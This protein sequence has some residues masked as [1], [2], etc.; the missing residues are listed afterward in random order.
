MRI[1]QYVAVLDTCVLAP[2]PLAD[3]LLRLGAEEFFT[4][5]WSSDILNELGGVLEKF[6]YTAAQIKYRLEQMENA[7]PEA[8]VEGY[9]MLLDSMKNDPKDRHVLAAA[10]KCGA[11]AIVTNNKKHFPR[12]YVVDE[13]G[14]ECISGDDFIR[15]QY[16][17]NPDLFITVLKQQ[18]EDADFGLRQLIAKH[19]PSLS[20]LIVV[21]E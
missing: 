2:M 8:R 13:L 19:V 3:T 15:H 9:T 14:L 12:Q 20:E 17:L 10:I 5:R 16:H 21:T 1:D 11:N 7:F 4:P 6:G 18:A